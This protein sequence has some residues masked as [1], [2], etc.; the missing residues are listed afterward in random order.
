MV[1]NLYLW[2]DEDVD[3]HV[4]HASPAPSGPRW[5]TPILNVEQQPLH[6]VRFIQSTVNGASSQS[7]QTVPSTDSND[8]TQSN[9]SNSSSPSLAFV[10]QC[11]GSIT[12]ASLLEL[13][14]YRI[15]PAHIPSFGPSKRPSWERRRNEER[16]LE[17]E[18]FGVF[19]SGWSDDITNGERRTEGAGV[20]QWMH[21]TV[22]AEF[23]RRRNGPAGV[24]AGRRNWLTVPRL[25]QLWK[26]EEE[27]LRRSSNSWLRS[28]FTLVRLKSADGLLSIIYLNICSSSNF[29]MLAKSLGELPLSSTSLTRPAFDLLQKVAAVDRR[30]W[31]R[32][33]WMHACTQPD[34]CLY[35]AFTKK[36]M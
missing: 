20:I 16:L 28:E 18:V 13:S 14:P 2:A 10:N 6:L 34:A 35:V 21:E 7:V 26:V 12:C 31:L 27:T 1:Q 22:V 32:V 36:P 8:S 33:I 17:L 11:C 30:T 29:D 19:W 3:T 9:H 24:W 4:V 15:Y 25:R 5:T 23:G